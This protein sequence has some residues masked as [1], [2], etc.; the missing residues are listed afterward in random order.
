MDADIEALILDRASHQVLQRA[1]TE[2]GF[3]S[4]HHDATEAVI[5]GETSL[6]EIQRVMGSL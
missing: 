2:K 4:M 6:S 3:R 1:V 5:R